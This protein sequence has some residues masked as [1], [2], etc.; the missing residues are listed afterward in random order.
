MEN[1]KIADH[2][3]ALRATLPHAEWKKGD[4]RS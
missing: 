4:G 3:D 2:W 1:S